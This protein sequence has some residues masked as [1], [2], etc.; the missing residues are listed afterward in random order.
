MMSAATVLNAHAVVY[1]W[2]WVNPQQ[3]HQFAN[4]TIEARQQ[5]IDQAPENRWAISN[6]IGEVLN[7][8]GEWE[9]NPLP[10]S[11][12]EKHL[13]RTRW[14]SPE[15]ALLFIEQTLPGWVSE[16]IMPGVAALRKIVSPSGRWL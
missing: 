8:H 7:N 9:D 12:T 5:F 13:K 16:G 4:I 6:G 1:Q 14:N 3:P 11:R 15:D 2:L 10:S